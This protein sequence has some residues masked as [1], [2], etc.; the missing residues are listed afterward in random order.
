MWIGETD[1]QTVEKSY[2]CAS[3]KQKQLRH[4]IVNFR[5]ISLTLDVCKNN[6]DN[7]INK[8][9]VLPRKEQL[10]STNKAVF[11]LNITTVHQVAYLT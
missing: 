2:D 7:G 6:E 9:P 11:R 8:S 3:S 5:P 4:D 1:I 10:L